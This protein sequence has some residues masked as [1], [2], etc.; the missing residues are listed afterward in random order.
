MTFSLTRI[1][2]DKTAAQVSADVTETE[3]GSGVAVPNWAHFLLYGIVTLQTLALTSGEAVS[4]YVKILNDENTIEPLNMP[5]PVHSAS[6]AG[7]VGSHLAEQV[8]FPILQPVTPT[9]IVR[10]KFA[11]DAATTGVHLVDVDLMFLSAKPTTLEKIHAQ[12]CAFTPMGVA[13]ADGT[14]VDIETIAKKTRDLIGIWAYMVAAGTEVAG[15]GLGGHL[16]VESTL[17]DWQKQQLRLNM[18][19]SGLGTSFVS[20]TKP[21]VYGIKE[22]L[23][24][25]DGVSKRPLP[26]I[27]IGQRQAFTFTPYNDR[28]V[29]DAIVPT[30][31]AALIWNE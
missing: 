2:K 17:K 18:I 7:A 24:L 1:I 15:E 11:F 4:G 28:D 14:A 26:S 16:T 12:K 31:R 30:F 20:Q 22:L 10:A 29:G 27:N 19:G 25:F 21:V 9:D 13:L 5:L 23:D 6:V 3:V 8:M